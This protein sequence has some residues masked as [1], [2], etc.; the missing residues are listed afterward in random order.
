[1]VLFPFLDFGGE[2]MQR[3]FK[4]WQN[5]DLLRSPVKNGPL[6]TF[7]RPPLQLAGA[8]GNEGMNLGIPLKET[9]GDGV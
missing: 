1:M 5:G 9:I 3:G 6:Q 8:I 2:N 7:E 4:W